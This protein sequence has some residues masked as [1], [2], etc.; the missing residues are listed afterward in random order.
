MKGWVFK[1]EL[2]DGVWLS[3]GAYYASLEAKSNTSNPVSH[4]AL[5]PLFH[6]TS[7]SVAMIKHSIDVIQKAVNLLNPGQV[8]IIC[9]DQPLYAVAKQIQ[10]NWPPLYG[11]GQLVVMFGPLHIEMGALRLLGEWLDQSGWTS[12]LVQANVASSGIADSFLRASHV[13]RTRRAHQLTACC[14]FILIHA[15]YD[16]YQSSLTPEGI[17]LN[18]QD[19]CNQKGLESPHFLFWYK[20]MNL[21]L[22]VFSFISSVRQG[23]FKLYVD[24]LTKLTPC[25]F[26]HEPWQLCSLATRTHQIH[27]II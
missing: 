24:S 2:E 5:L 27:D 16:Q 7:K 1:D 22:L 13:G 10:W 4:T 9:M 11:E 6:E 17:Q 26:C 23:N 8:P 18:F 21:E 19:W 15:A 14:M 12:A 20:T 25:F 3:W